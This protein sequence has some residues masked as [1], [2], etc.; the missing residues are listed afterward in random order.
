MKSF[1]R[2]GM[3]MKRILTIQDISCFGKCSL[4][5]ALPIL[6]AMGIETV[7]L[8]TAVLSTH[9]DLYLQYIF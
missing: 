3:I 1:I 9:K 5:V 2:E 8:P 4:T 7:I 6:S